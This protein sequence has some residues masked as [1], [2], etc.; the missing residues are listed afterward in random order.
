MHINF[1]KAEEDIFS[2]V[3]VHT[4]KVVSMWEAWGTGSSLLSASEHHAFLPLLCLSSYTASPRNFRDANS[5]ILSQAEPLE[6]ECSSL[7]L[8]KIHSLMMTVQ[9][10]A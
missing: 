10:K 8:F 3:N 7:R 6:I 4:V 1:R 5:W 9:V 2:K